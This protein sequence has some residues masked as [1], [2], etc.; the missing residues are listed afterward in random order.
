MD[1]SQKRYQEYLDFIKKY[2][3]YLGNK[4]DYKKGEIEMVF[5]ITLFPKCEENSA[6]LMINAGVP[7]EEAKKRARI[8]VFDEN[9]WGVSIHEP[10]RL[11]DGSYT[12][13]NRWLSWGT[14]ESGVAGVVAVPVLTDGRF[15]FIKNFRNATK[16]WCMEF[17]RGGKDP[18]NSVIKTVKNE[19]SEEIGAAIIEDPTK[20]GEVFPDSGVLA[21]RVEI[22]LVKIKLT[23]M[24]ER[25]TTEA[26]KGLV[27]VTK[28]DLKNIIKEQKYTD[29]EG[30]SY[31]FKDGF[32]LSAL[33][34]LDRA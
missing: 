18:G 31:E 17:P 27:F 21:S 5:D 32:T 22:F 1:D 20:I 4:G 33:A 34:L 28:N 29:E 12:T 23:G 3:K 10:L 9:K 7:A 24:P 19:L 30:K 15:V 26:I 13:F 16:N 14:L 11:T 8:G 2:P 6:Q 25:E